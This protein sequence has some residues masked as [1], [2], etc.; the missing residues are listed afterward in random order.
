MTVSKKRM[1]KS[2]LSVLTSFGKSRGPIRG[3]GVALRVDH[4][5]W[6]VHCT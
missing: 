1:G 4:E 5:V 2:F 6:K 3:R